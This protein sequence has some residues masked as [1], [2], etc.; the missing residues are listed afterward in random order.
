MPTKGDKSASSSAKPIDMR[1]LSNRPSY[2]H[3]RFL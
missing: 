3:V 2:K 1:V